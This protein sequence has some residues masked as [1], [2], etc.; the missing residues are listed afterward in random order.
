MNIKIICG[1]FEEQFLHICIFPLGWFRSLFCILLCNSICHLDRSTTKI[2][3]SNCVC[4]SLSQV[5]QQ[6]IDG[7]LKVER[8]VLLVTCY[9]TNQ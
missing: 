4:I 6:I 2:H 5:S 7:N 9:W 8:K 1:S 3:Y